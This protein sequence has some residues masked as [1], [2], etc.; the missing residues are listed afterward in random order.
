MEFLLKEV[1][2]KILSPCGEVVRDEEMG[3]VKKKDHVNIDE[4][5]HHV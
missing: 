3:Q 5:D 2:E 4:V 1:V